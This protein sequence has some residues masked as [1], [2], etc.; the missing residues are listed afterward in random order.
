MFFHDAPTTE[1]TVPANDPF[2]PFVYL[3][4]VFDLNCLKRL[5]IKVSVHISFSPA[6][7]K[8]NF[9][10]A[11][12]QIWWRFWPNWRV[13]AVFW[14]PFPYHFRV[15]S[16]LLGSLHRK[17]YPFWPKGT[18]MVRIRHGYGT[19]TTRPVMHRL[20]T[21]STRQFGQSGQIGQ[22]ILILEKMILFL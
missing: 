14:R 22:Q 15:L 6:G 20:P 8:H 10:F 18:D 11:Q 21:P 13:E 1:P 9:C 7:R 19:V 16:V 12:M 5:F 17:K 3:P 2:A 4:I